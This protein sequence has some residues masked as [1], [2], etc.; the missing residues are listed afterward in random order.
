M[1][2]IRFE[3]EKPPVIT[4][5]PGVSHSDMRLKLTT[6]ASETSLPPG[7]T[8]KSGFIDANSNNVGDAGEWNGSLTISGTLNNTDSSYT[9][10]S[11]GYQDFNIRLKADLDT[12][13]QS[14]GWV[15]SK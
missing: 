5:L 7:L 13:C 15:R 8:A 12:N 9:F 2:E 4:G 3:A 1:N 14:Q 10:N 11:D 6:V